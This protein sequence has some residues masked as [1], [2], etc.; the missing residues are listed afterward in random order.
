MTVGIIAKEKFTQF[1]E[2][3]KVNLVPAR[4]LSHHIPVF[5]VWEDSVDYQKR[6]VNNSSINLLTDNLPYLNQY[7]RAIVIWNM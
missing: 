6:N 1:I 4:G 5:K 2:H 3:G 7:A